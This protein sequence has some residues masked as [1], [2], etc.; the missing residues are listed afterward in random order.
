MKKLA[1]ELFE[2]QPDL[3]HQLVTI[4]NPNTLMSHGVPVCHQ[5]FVFSHPHH[6]LVHILNYSFH[7]IGSISSVII[8]HSTLINSPDL[9]QLWSTDAA[10]PIGHAPH[11]L[12][13]RQSWRPPQGRG[14]SV[15]FSQGHINAG[16][17]DRIGP[18]EWENCS[19]GGEYQSKE[20]HKESET[21]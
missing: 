21:F 16:K 18:R 13:G 3:L 7:F 11:P 17:L 8:K 6:L 1:P 20:I 12:V 19:G 5:A 14:T 15:P 4:M 2:S 9:L 10:M